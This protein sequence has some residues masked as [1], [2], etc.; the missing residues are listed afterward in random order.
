MCMEGSV[1]GLRSKEAGVTVSDGLGRMQKS[2]L[3]VCCQY[4]SHAVVGKKGII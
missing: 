4:S 1:I 2:A 3:S